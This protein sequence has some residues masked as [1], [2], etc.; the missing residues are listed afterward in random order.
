MLLN[1][2][3]KFNFE[4]FTP[5]LLK[6]QTWGAVVQKPVSLRAYIHKPKQWIKFNSRLALIMLLVTGPST[7]WNCTYKNLYST[8]SIALNHNSELWNFSQIFPTWTLFHI[9]LYVNK[10]YL[11]PHREQSQS[12][13][14]RSSSLHL[15]QSSPIWGIWILWNWECFPLTP[16][17]FFALLWWDGQSKRRLLATI[18][19][20]TSVNFLK[21]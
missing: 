1:E 13:W 12:F 14:T 7:M 20:P 15:N 6:F 4:I 2:Y 18:P 5:C 9:R 21:D 16:A 3:H 10:T 17:V 8:C 19:K 11:V